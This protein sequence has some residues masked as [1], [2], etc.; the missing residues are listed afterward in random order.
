[1]LDEATITDL[2]EELQPRLLAWLKANQV[3]HSHAEDIVQEAFIRLWQHREGIR[4]CAPE[5]AAL[6]WRIVRNLRIDFFRR[7]QHCD[8]SD[9][10]IRLA[11]Q[12]GG[13]MKPPVAESDRLQLARCVQEE[14]ETMP[15]EL[16]LS[17]RLYHS[18][19]LSVREIAVRTGV[20]ETL[21]KVRIHRARLRLRRR[22]SQEGY[23]I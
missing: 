9:D 13:E 21:A 20:S 8:V 1:M 4:E 10:S 18:D 22:L 16:A 14:L 23:S 17:W 2:Y 3:A 12:S 11:E 5:M 6:I 7:Q 15:E 19:E